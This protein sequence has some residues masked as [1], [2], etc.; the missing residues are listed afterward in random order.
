MN[1]CF[2]L[3]CCCL[4]AI[5]LHPANAQSKS[6][7][8]TADPAKPAS[9]VQAKIPDADSRMAWWRDAR[10]GMFIHWGLY[11]VPAGEWKD[12]TGYG[13]W[14]RTSAEIPLD[15]YDQFRT[16]FNPVKFDADAWVK[17]ARDAGM[18]YIVITSKHHDG[19]CMFDT[20]ETDFNKN[21]FVFVYAQ[22][23]THEGKRQL[24]AYKVV[25]D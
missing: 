14:I 2:L 5:G 23:E 10:F 12:K 19:F 18:K 16:K 6:K 9:S 15:D 13:E 22:T 24:F 20:K 11:A 17:M 1:R 25:K 8:K 3:I 4:F 21:D 7:S